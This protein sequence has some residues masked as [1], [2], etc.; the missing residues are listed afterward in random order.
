MAILGAVGAGVLVAFISPLMSD[1]QLAL[2]IIGA[3][4]TGILVASISWHFIKRNFR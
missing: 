3:A 1:G 4:G 2:A